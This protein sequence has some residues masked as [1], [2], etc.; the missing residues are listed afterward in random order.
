MNRKRLFSL[1]VFFA[2]T[3][4]ITAKTYLISIGVSKYANNNVAKNL[5][6]AA[7][8]ADTIASVFRGEDCECIVLK[9]EDA[10]GANII[11]MTQKLFAKATKKDKIMFFFSG[12]GNGVGFCAHDYGVS[13]EGIISFN[14]VKKL[15]HAS[16]ARG[17]IIMADACFSGAIRTPE[18]L[19]DSVSKIIQKQQ[20]VL[21]F[22]SSRGN[23][24]SMER[25]DMPNGFFTTYL[26]KGL[27]GAADANNNGKITA[28]EI[29]AYVSKNVK[30]ESNGE[31]HSNIWGNFN[32]NWIISR[33]MPTSK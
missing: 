21:L 24:S 6:L 20:Q 15:F 18:L 27:R 2:V 32:L 1:L 31:Q 14:D 33:V 29:S 13:S 28:G 12:H 7:A 22:L 25:I 23:E 16:I 10:T 30:R 8:D 11:S 5:N 4:A 17:K 26:A 9:N 3:I 19:P